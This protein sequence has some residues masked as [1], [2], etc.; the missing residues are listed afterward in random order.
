MEIRNPCDADEMSPS[1]VDVLLAGHI[2]ASDSTRIS[3]PSR[4]K[5]KRQDKENN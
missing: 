4:A 5:E 3:K 2:F 1:N